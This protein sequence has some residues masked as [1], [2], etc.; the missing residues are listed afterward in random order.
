MEVTIEEI[1]QQFDT[2]PEELK[3]AIIDINIDD[4]IIEIGNNHNLTVGQIQQLS[5]EVHVHAYGML[6]MEGMQQ[7]I[8]DS[9]KLEPEKT[10]TIVEEINEKI[11]IPIR[12]N[13]QEE[14]VETE[15][16][17]EENKNIKNTNLQETEEKLKNPNTEQ[18]QITNII[19]QKL[20]NGFK[21]QTSIS[22]HN[23]NNIKPPTSTPSPTPETK[24]VETQSSTDLKTDPYRELPE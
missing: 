3:L 1:Q 8:Q 14:E 23:L 5:L 9:L 13:M 4:K 16:G 6:P 11:F 20:V 19:N 12:K 18:E 17:G 2:L 24:N 22:E 15:G 21:A 7:S 10:K